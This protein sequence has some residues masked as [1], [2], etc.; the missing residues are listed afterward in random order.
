METN[1]EGLHI[2]AFI[3]LNLSVDGLCCLLYRHNVQSNGREASDFTPVYIIGCTCILSVLGEDWPAVRPTH[4]ELAPEAV[5]YR[6][7]TSQPESRRDGQR[8]LAETKG[9]VRQ[10]SVSNY[11]T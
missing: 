2:C 1:T 10:T 6:T 4:E 9:R 5:L 3:N 8:A 7:Q 11:L